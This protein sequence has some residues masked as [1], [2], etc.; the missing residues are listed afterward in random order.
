MT[1]AAPEVQL[2][3]LRHAHAG[4]PVAWEGPDERRPLSAKGER[5]AE[6]LARFLKRIDFCPD[7]I[8]SSPKLRSVQTATPVATSLGLKVRVDVRL[9]DAP[10]LDE[11]EA[12][13]ADAGGPRRPVLVGHDPGFSS[14]VALICGAPSIP[15]RKGAMARID[16]TRP[17]QPGG[18]TLRWLI[19][20]DLLEGGA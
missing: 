5:Q 6:R 11:L 15:M 2:Y 13:L 19:P 17:V 8:L 12:M 18:G 7:V 3:L 1:H 9:S 16:A 20:P 10:G 14:L 4:D